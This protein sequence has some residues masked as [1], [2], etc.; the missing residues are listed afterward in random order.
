M[1]ISKL[2]KTLNKLATRHEKRIEKFQ[3]EASKFFHPHAVTLCR[4]IQK[5]IPEF[6]GCMLAMRH[7]YL[8]P[9]D[10]LI[11]IIDSCDGE[12][13]HSRL[14]DL[15][16]Y[17]NTNGAFNTGNW[18]VQLPE[19]TLAALEELDELANYI[20]DT[21]SMVSELHVKLDKRRK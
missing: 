10:L 12:V 15:L 4:R 21:Y 14:N 16:E 3:V 2:Y 19:D 9:R 1:T 7:L 6:T 13:C 18:K 20:D 17:T 5:G 8:E 11:P